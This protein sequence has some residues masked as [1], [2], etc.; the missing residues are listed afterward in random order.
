MKHAIEILD[1]IQK[2]LP[3]VIIL[4][5]V[6]GFLI[7]L[8]A[9][10]LTGSTMTMA[11]ALPGITVAIVWVGRCCRGCGTIDGHGRLGRWRRSTS[12]IVDGKIQCT[13]NGRNIF[14][15]VIN[16]PEAIMLIKSYRRIRSGL[17]K[18]RLGSHYFSRARSSQ[19][20]IPQ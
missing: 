16:M 8:M 19:G 13:F 9:H 10:L 7:E 11:W 6:V 15:V 1:K 4:L 3:A 5:G 17:D 2:P 14:P 18:Q 20:C 12:Q